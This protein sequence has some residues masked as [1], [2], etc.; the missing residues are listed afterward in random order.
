M[1]DY[2]FNSQFFFQ[3]P[4]LDQ[5]VLYMANFS[6]TILQQ[7]LCHPFRSY[8]S[9]SIRWLQYFPGADD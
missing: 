4:L 9:A 7:L 2:F 1:K 3:S 8:T 5:A 6:C